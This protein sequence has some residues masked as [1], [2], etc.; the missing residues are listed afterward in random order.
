MASFGTRLLFLAV[1][2]INAGNAFSFI[3]VECRA[4]NYGQY[5]QQSMLDC[6]VKTAQEA[7]DAKILVVTWKKAGVALAVFARG[8]RTQEPR[9]Q[10][11]KPFWDNN[12]MNVSLLI[13]TTKTTDSGSYECS[14]MT[15]SGSHSTSTSLSVTAKYNTPTVRSQPAANI[16]QNTDVT[17]FCNSD[18]GYPKGELRWSDEH[19]EDWTR[20]SEPE[21]KQTEDGLFSLS[22]KLTLLRGSVF[23][24]YTCSV[25]NATGTQEGEVTFDIPY[26]EQFKDPGP[27]TVSPIS[28]I[29]APVV[30]IGS[31]IVGLLLVL[32][33]FLKRR[34]QRDSHEIHMHDQDAEKGG[35]QE[36]EPCFQEDTP[37]ND[38]N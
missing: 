32:V 14:V 31:L 26:S 11:A 20:S 25:H 21:V 38:H 23:F 3:N 34:S 6:V 24:K 22:S 2:C 16:P 17:L 7:A 35:R 18:G 30:V 1:L 37:G 33:L 5:G 8:S 27:T 15:D 28:K 19:N 4:D 29:V 36:M 12:H 10:F 9:F 13:T